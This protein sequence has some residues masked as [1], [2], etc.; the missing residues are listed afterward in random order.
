MSS[1]APADRMVAWRR[2]SWRGFP[3]DDVCAE[4][5]R[6]AIPA[7]LKT[8]SPLAA[9][10]R[11]EKETQTLRNLSIQCSIE[12]SDSRHRFTLTSSSNTGRKSTVQAPANESLGQKRGV[13]RE[14]AAEDGRNGEDC[15]PKW[16]MFGDIC[17]EC[18]ERRD[19]EGVT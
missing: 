3:R 4:P 15:H 18:G 5:P 13:W 1:F 7:P 6:A 12:A 19:E 8:Q 11:A 9:R 2:K 17:H 16:R 14:S 10:Q